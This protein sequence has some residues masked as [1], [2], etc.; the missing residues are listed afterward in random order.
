MDE[1]QW[2]EFHFWLL[3]S[4][5]YT[6]QKRQM[7]QLFSCAPP[8]IRVSDCVH[9]HQAV[10]KLISCIAQMTHIPELQLSVHLLCN[11]IPRAQLWYL[12]KTWILSLLSLVLLIPELFVSSVITLNQRDKWWDLSVEEWSGV[13]ETL[14]NSLE[15]T[16]QAG[17]FHFTSPVF[18]Y[19]NI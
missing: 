8:V 2:K 17:R 11:R 16:A 6:S 4:P 13:K 5:F 3:F 15:D 1:N 7:C 14:V 12:I 19:A 10:A 18:L 9:T